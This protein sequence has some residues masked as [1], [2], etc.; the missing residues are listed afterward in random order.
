MTAPEWLPEG[1]A[2]RVTV[3]QGRAEWLE[4]RN[5]EGHT[6]GGTTAAALLGSSPWA[7]PWDVWA[8][9]HAPEEGKPRD[10]S[11]A[12]TR[13][14]VLWEPYVVSAYAETRGAEVW[15]PL[16]IASAQGR[17]WARGS[18]DGITRRDGEIGILEIKCPYRRDDWGK[19]GEIAHTAADLVCPVYYAIQCYWY[20]AVSGLPWADVVA[21][22]GPHDLRV[23]RIV[24]DPTF[25]AALLSRVEDARD[26]IMVSGVEPDLDASEAC[27]RALQARERD[28]AA[29]LT[30]DV[31]RAALGYYRARDAEKEAAEARKLAQ[32]RL[33]DT[34]EHESYENA[35][36]KRVLWLTK[37]R[38][39][40]HTPKLSEIE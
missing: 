18:F 5:G 34:M 6:V 15:A 29:P 33:L 21:F 16:A 3:Y 30:E 31:H 7:G 22:F 39:Y 26:R 19:D 36:G 17:P 11:N 14:G 38:I 37:G 40:P 32:N 12:A 24:A 10:Q 20:L 9:A 13:A 23:V 4:A 27:K 2:E 35:D 25:Q 28:E 1:L 8:E